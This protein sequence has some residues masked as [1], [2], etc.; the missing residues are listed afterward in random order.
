ML[1]LAARQSNYLRNP[2]RPALTGP[3]SQPRR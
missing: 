3:R 2:R 1:A